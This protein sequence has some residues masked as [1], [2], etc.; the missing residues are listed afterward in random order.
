MNVHKCAWVHGCADEDEYTWIYMSVE[1]RA[2]PIMLKILP[3]MLLSTAQKVTQYAW[4]ILWLN[5]C[6]E[7]YH[8][9]YTIVLF[10]WLHYSIVRLQPV[11]LN[12]M[13]CC[14]TLMF[15]LL[16]SW[17]NFCPTLCQVDM[18]TTVYHK[19]FIRIFIYKSG[20]RCV[21]NSND[22]DF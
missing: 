14:S 20:D 12:I 11:A 13:L 2:Q 15:D 4:S 9:S 8:S 6:T 19:G 21:N 5:C 7:L 17:E 16:C 22:N 3:I 18:T 1:S 10:L